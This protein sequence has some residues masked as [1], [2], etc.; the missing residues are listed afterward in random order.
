MQ[1]DDSDSEESKA[2]LSAPRMFVNFNRKLHK[3]D[4]L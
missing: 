2:N 3:C 4:P 1:D